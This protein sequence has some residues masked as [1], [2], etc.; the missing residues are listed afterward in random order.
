MLQIIISMQ[1]GS[2]NRELYDYDKTID[3][4]TQKGSSKTVELADVVGLSQPRVRVQ[5][6]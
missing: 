1:G 3:Y 6:V 5:A 2:I 4:I